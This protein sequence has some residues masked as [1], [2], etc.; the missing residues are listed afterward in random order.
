MQNL[1]EEFKDLKVLLE[2]EVLLVLVLKVH[3]VI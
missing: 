3:E 1:T 2:I